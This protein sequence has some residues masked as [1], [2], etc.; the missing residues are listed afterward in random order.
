MKKHLITIII[1]SIICIAC[2]FGTFVFYEKIRGSQAEITSLQ[3]SIQSLQIQ[4]DRLS[5]KKAEKGTVLDASELDA[6]F[7]PAD[8]ALGFVEYIENLAVSSGLGYRINLFDSE[9]N[10]EALSNDREFLKTSLTTSGT[11]KNTRNFISLIQSL[12]YN[13]RITKVDLKRGADASLAGGANVSTIKEPWT[14]IID[15]SVMKN[16]DKSSQVQN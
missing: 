5:A 7:V 16:I 6:F 9:Q 12:P 10:P 14:M 8:G 1:V 11:L 2:G 3:Q 4:A 15:F 13:V